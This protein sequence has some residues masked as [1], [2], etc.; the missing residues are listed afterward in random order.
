MSDETAEKIKIICVDEG[1]GLARQVIDIFGEERISLSFARS[2]DDV[3]DRF[4]REAFDLMLFS[5]SVAHRQPDDALELLELIC[6]KCPGTP[7]LFFAPPGRLKMA[8]QALRAGV[9]HYSL[10]PVTDEELKLLVETALSRRPQLGPNLLLR[11][12][13]EKTTFE[14]MIGRSTA[15]RQVYRQIRQA[16]ATD[17]PVLLSGETGTGKELAALAIHELSSRAHGPYVPVHIGALP[18]DLVASELF[19]HERGAFSG[20][21]SLRKGCFEVAEGGTVFMDEIATI[22]EKMQISLLRLLETNE[23]CRIGSQRSIGVNVRMIAA[24]NADLAEEIRKGNFREDLYYR[25]DVLHVAMPP[26]RERHGD[27]HLLVDHFIKNA[28]DTFGK[29]I[30]GLSPGFISCLESYP[31]PGNVRELKNVIQRSVISAT[32][33]ILDLRQL[34]P[35]ISQYRNEDTKMTIR[36]GMTIAEVEKELII[37][38][39]EHAGQNRSRASEMLGISRRSLYNK[40]QRY[41]IGR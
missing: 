33:D 41:A 35:R 26:L 5:S 32:G 18:T 30:R 2:L 4:E 3:G 22:D 28:C 23:Y 24:S 19:G 12:E 1:R 20:A 13:I 29:S 40:M 27:I 37:L 31:W 9:F 10:L 25:L 39:L 21:T 15:M 34:P 14:R 16:A 8:H 17:I 6:V 11:S 38:T 7:V 36:V